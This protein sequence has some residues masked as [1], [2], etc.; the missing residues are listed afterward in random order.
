MSGDEDL[1]AVEGRAVDAVFDMGEHR[2][3]HREIRRRFE[4]EQ[5]R[6][7]T[8]VTAGVEHEVSL[9]AVFAAVLATHA[10]LRVRQIDLDTDDGFAV[11]DFHALQRGLIGQQ[12][13]EVGALDLEGRRLALG[14]GVTEIESAVTLAPGKRGAGF[15]LE[16]RRIDGV[17]H[18]CLFDEVQAVRQQAFADGKAWEMLT[19]DHQHVM[20]LAFEQR[21]GDGTRRA[22]ADD[23][24]LATF[25]F[26]GGHGGSLPRRQL[27][28]ESGA[29]RPVPAAVSRSGPS[30]SAQSTAPG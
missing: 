25:H 29:C 21:G 17:Q 5:A 9:D 13:V 16:P 15:H 7:H 19:L 8:T 3:A 4:V 20:T 27:S 28:G 6:Q 24:D 1:G 23:H 18:A 10:E 12:F 22:C 11:A 26:N 2:L 14:K 30:A